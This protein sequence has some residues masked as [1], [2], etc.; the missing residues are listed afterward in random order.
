MER[1]LAVVLRGLPRIAITPASAPHHRRVRGLHMLLHPDQE[2]LISTTRPTDPQTRAA[3]AHAV[4]HLLQLHAPQTHRPAPRALGVRGP[5]QVELALVEERRRAH[6]ALGVHCEVAKVHGERLRGREVEAARRALVGLREV[7]AREVHV[8]R[9]LVRERH[10]ARPAFVR[11]DRREGRIGPDPA[12]SRR[13]RRQYRHRWAEG[14][15]G[16]RC[17]GLRRGVWVLLVLAMLDKPGLFGECLSASGATDGHSD[18]GIEMGSGSLLRL[19][20]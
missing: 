14:R 11:C 10:P 17:M 12:R 3:S 7:P 16:C 19:L 5:V 4:T 2:E 6:A 9:G 15:H 20:E 13:T 18:G 1:G 8:V